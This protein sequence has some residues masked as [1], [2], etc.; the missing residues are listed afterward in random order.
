MKEIVLDEFINEMPFACAAHRAKIRFVL[1]KLSNDI[2]NLCADNAEADVIFLHKYNIPPE[3]Y[4][5]YV[6]KN[7]ILNVKN[8]IV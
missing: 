4:E 3:D 1:N 7:S 5:V 8:V 6:L 2:I